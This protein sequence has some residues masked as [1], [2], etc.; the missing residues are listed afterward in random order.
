MTTPSNPSAGFEFPQEQRD[1][2]DRRLREFVAKDQPVTSVRPERQANTPPPIVRP[3]QP[4]ENTRV[5]AMRLAQASS[6]GRP[7]VEP[8]PTPHAD[9]EGVSISLPSRFLFYPFKDLYIKPFR[10]LHLAKLAKAN[11]SGS[12]QMMVEAVS[13]VLQ[14]PGYASKCIA[15]DLTIADFNAVMYWLRFN[16]FSKKQM[17]VTSYCDNHAHRAKVASKE[18]PKDSLKITTIYTKSDIQTV[19]LEYAPDPDKY[20]ITYQGDQIKLKP[21]TVRDLV[22]LLDHPDVNDAE[23]QYKARVASV[24]DISQ[25]GQQISLAKKIAIVEDLDPD[26]AMLAM[27]FSELLDNYGVQET[28]NT[29]CME[30]GASGTVQIVVDAPTFLS[31]EF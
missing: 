22:E 20:V 21:E 12:M 24:L 13:S 27:E 19:E 23:F 25:D 2:M 29:K 31:P 7:V 28:V 26:Q 11:D 17:R 1:L 4:Q 30:C 3:M 18:L 6:G 5:A 15:M 10:V 14:A 8:A 9:P 16:S